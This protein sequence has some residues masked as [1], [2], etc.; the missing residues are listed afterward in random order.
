[1]TGVAAGVDAAVG[2]AEESSAFASGV[3]SG[4][5]V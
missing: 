4:V 2:N 5:E 3:D 1:V